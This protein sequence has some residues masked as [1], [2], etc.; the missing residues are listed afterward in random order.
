MANAY[1]VD[2][3]ARAVRA[4]ERGEGTLEEIAAIFAV[5]AR[6]LQR[7]IARQRDTGS[8]VPTPKAGGWR[9]PIELPLLHDVIAA[10]PDA[11]I[12][13]LC[14]EYNRRAP[15]AARTTATSFGRAMRR[16]GYVLKKTA[17]AERGRPP[18]RPGE[19]GGVSDV[20]RT[21]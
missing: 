18:G 4:Y 19:A 5:H 13:E 1:G 10:A 12:G 7:W 21:D 15:A 11:T 16:A 2:L 17:A 3:R 9:C 20:G 6:T 8:L 14:W